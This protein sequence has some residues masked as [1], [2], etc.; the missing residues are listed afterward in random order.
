MISQSKP[1]CSKDCDFSHNRSQAHLLYHVKNKIPTAIKYNE[2]HLLPKRDDFTDQGLG[3][4]FN[5]K[6]KEGLPILFQPIDIVEKSDWDPEENVLK[7]RAYLFGILP[8]GSKTCVILDN[9]MVHA[10]VL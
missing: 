5:E 9:V 2:I 7:Y 10:D 1:G 3:R 4:A 6:I 8:C